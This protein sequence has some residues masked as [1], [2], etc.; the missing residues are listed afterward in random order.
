MAQANSNTEVDRS[1]Q[2]H[3]VSVGLKRGGKSLIAGET[4]SFELEARLNDTK[5]SKEGPL[6]W[7]TNTEQ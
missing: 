5:D 6:I 2:P 1:R 7:S 3:Y 4:G